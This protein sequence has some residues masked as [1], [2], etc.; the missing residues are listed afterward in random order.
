MMVQIGRIGQQ[1]QETS[2][3]DAKPAPVCLIFSFLVRQR[4]DSG[5]QFRTPVCTSSKEWTQLLFGVGNPRHSF[6]PLQRAS[7]EKGTK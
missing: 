3:H 2:L 7:A 1:S 5:F 6:S 4:L